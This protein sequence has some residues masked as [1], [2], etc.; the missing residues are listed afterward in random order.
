MSSGTDN[1]TRRVQDREFSDSHENDVPPEWSERP[2]C[3]EAADAAY[4]TGPLQPDAGARGGQDTACHSPKWAARDSGSAGDAEA[5]DDSGQPDANPFA[6]HGTEPLPTWAVDPEPV[7]LELADDDPLAE[8][9]PIA[10]KGSWSGTFWSSVLHVWLII[11]LAGLTM[12]EPLSLDIPAIESRMEA[13]E[14]VEDIE[15]LI[16]FELANPDDRELD[17][18]KVVNARSVGAIEKSRPK[19]ESPPE[20]LRDVQTEEQRLQ[21]YDIPEGREISESVVIK[22]TTG[23]AIVQ[24]DS[25]LDRVTWEIAR[26]LQE[27]KVLVIWL[28]DAS[29]SLTEQRAAIARR[30]DRIYGELDALQHEDQIPRFQRPLLTAVAAYGLRTEFLTAA[31]TDD[32]REIQQAIETVPLDASGVENVFTAVTQ[33]MRRWGEYRALQGRRIMLV[34][35]TDESGDDFAEHETAIN[36]CRRYG[37]GAYVIGPAAVFGRREG[38]VPYVA[39]E[40]GQTYR[41]PVDLGPETAMFESLQMPF[42]FDGPQYEYLSAGYGPYALARLVKE[43]SGVYFMTSMTTMDGLAPLGEFDKLALKPFEPE[44]DFGSRAEYEAELLAHPLRAAVVRAARL[45]RDFQPEGTPQLRLR[46]QPDN[47]RQVATDAQR[48]VARSEYMVDAILQAFPP[49]IEA[50]YDTEPS[51]RWRMVFNLTYGRLLALKV[52]CLEYNS[53][54]AELKG[55]LTEADIASTSNEWI[56]R[57]SETINYATQVRQLAAKAEQLLARVVDEAP[58]TPFAVLAQRELKDAFG[59]RVIERFIPPPAPP[60]PND[61]PPP[62]PPKKRIQLAPDP[63]KPKPTP[64]PA[65]LPPKLPRL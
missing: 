54:L 53:A 35:V 44:Y 49:G 2:G 26:N 60:T 48:T 24:I 31:P 5:G 28:L 46:V 30:L 9:A 57:P 41:L 45:S 37:A 11:T 21:M 8:A 6:W 18:R 10:G 12:Q 52:R 33:V 32:F 65:P 55:S 14:P 34:T 39:P 19:M 17:V 22:G 16:E 27:R 50:Q 51:L 13:A 1:L 38:Y 64:K 40:N 25:A 56:F 47:F 4:Q 42:W 36:V 61:S 7:L 3:D 15:E 59:M 23:E 62:A 58:G 43:T 20:M 63:P 29:E